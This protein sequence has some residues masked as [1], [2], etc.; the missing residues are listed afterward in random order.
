MPDSTA[1]LP[2]TPLSL[3]ILL[4]LAEEDLHGYAILKSIEQDGGVHIRPGTGTLYAALQRMMDEGLI[5]SAESQEESGDSRRRYYAI[6]PLGRVVAQAEL[7]RLATLVELG[8]EK[9]LVATGRTGVRPSEGP[10]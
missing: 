5:L 6:S 7:K 1:F 9:R 4:A 3:G 10:A 8:I 2:L